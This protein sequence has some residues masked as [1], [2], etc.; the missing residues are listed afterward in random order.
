MIGEANVNSNVGLAFLKPKPYPRAFKRVVKN[1]ALSIYNWTA[2][3]D[4]KV[5]IAQDGTLSGVDL[6]VEATYTAP[7]VAGTPTARAINPSELLESIEVRVNGGTVIQ[8]FSGLEAFVTGQWAREEAPVDYVGATTAQLQTNAL[9]I[10]IRA[11][12]HIDFHALGMYPEEHGLIQANRLI[13]FH[14]QIKSGAGTAV[15]ANA[16]TGVPT[17]TGTIKVINRYVLHDNAV[18]RGFGIQRKIVREFNIAQNYVAYAIPLPKGVNY[19]RIF[20]FT[21]ANATNDPSDA[22]VTGDV[23][24]RVGGRY[25]FQKDA[26]SLRS[27]NLEWWTP[28][29]PRTGVLCIDFHRMNRKQSERNQ[30]GPL[31]TDANGGDVILELGVTNVAG[32]KIRVIPCEALGVTQA[33][34]E[35]L[36]V[37]AV[38]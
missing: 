21:T 32:N 22:I 38:G 18:A 9:A 27:D 17:L 12:Y 10:P 24:V 31:E 14:L 19:D 25:M 35:I 3:E 20:I 28:N 23:A 29:F 33:A 34:L 5:D 13:S 36:K 11:L 2:G 30:L 15:I 6:L 16:I 8:K 1:P 37:N 4:K 26:V 7:A